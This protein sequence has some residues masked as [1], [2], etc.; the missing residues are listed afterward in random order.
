V[1]LF[2]DKACNVY[3]YKHINKTKEKKMKTYIGRFASNYDSTFEVV[4]LKRTEKSV[5]FIHP[6]NKQKKR[7]KI[8]KYNNDEFFMP[9]G[10]HSMCPVITL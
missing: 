10:N 5:T 9:L 1:N 8:H 4:V 6:I 2:V 7:A 3:Y